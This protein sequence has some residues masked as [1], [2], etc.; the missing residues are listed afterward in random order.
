MAAVFAS[1][2]RTTRRA[3]ALARPSVRD[4]LPI[5][6]FTRAGA[7]I[8]LKLL[9]AGA[10]GRRFRS[11][12]A[13]G[14]C[15][16]HAN[17]YAESQ[18][19]TRL[20]SGLLPLVAEFTA[21]WDFNNSREIGPVLRRSYFIY[22]VLFKR[23]EAVREL[24]ERE[25]QA[26]PAD[27]EFAGLSFERYFNLVFAIY[28]LVQASLKNWT[29]IVDV[30]PL[31]R[32]LRF[33]PQELRSFAQHSVRVAGSWDLEFGRSSAID[34]FAQSINDL[35]WCFDRRQL[36]SRPLLKLADGRLLVTDQQL[37]VENVSTGL[38]W[39]LLKALPSSAHGAFSTLWGKLFEEY[40]Q[41]LIEHYL[42]STSMR[43]VQF[44]R[45]ELDAI[46][47]TED[48]GIVV[49]EVKAGFLADTAKLSRDER[50]MIASLRKRYLQN[51]K[52]KPKGVAQLARAVAALHGGAV[53]GVAKPRYVQPVLVVEDPSMQSLAVNAI[54]DEEYRQLLPANTATP[55]TVLTIDELDV[56][57]RSLAVNDLVWDDVF[58]S[59]TVNN[60]AAAVS[61]SAALYEL[62][63]A[64]GLRI[65]PDTFLRETGEQLTAML[66]C[67]TGAS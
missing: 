12:G 2:L 56:I 46:A 19:S 50:L 22:N 53:P 27:V 54:L 21:A 63:G 30:T 26:R 11:S 14:Q 48:G 8:N 58:R 62:A 3:V 6:V 57:L 59:H 49:F 17:D 34:R 25:L 16:L 43:S 31:A 15:A 7:T 61:V 10:A 37:L 44:A 24:F 29:S 13:I 9:I 38:R 66:S 28:A 39:H 60:K 47:Y 33:S 41:L 51:E 1:I 64:R 32:D 40:V 18:D 4:R 55:L 35:S 65:P 42:P 23:S 52:R 5:V 67:L 45:G 20:Q 36:R